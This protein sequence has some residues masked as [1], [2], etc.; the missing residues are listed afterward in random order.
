MSS[1]TIRLNGRDIELAVTESHC[2]TCS[3]LS[4]TDVDCRSWQYQGQTHSTP[5][6]AM[7]IEAILRSLYGGADGGPDES[8]DYE[9]PENLRRFFVAKEES[10]S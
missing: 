10:S 4:G 5:P 7:V 8:L 3:Q 9:V 2:N 6:K 1:P